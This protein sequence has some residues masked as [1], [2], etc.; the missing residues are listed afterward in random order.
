MVLRVLLILVAS[1]LSACT[2]NTKRVSEQKMRLNLY[3]EPPSLDPRKFTDSTSA[4]VLVMLFEGLTR[5][6][7]DHKP[8]PAAAEEILVSK[9][10]CVY[11]FKL[12]ETYWSNGERLT[13]ED[14]AY[15]WRKILDPK[16]PSLFAYKLYII[17]NAAEAKEGKLPIDDVGIRVV[18][19][20][21]LEVTLNHPASYFLELT[22]FPTFYPV[23]KKIA[24]SSAEWAAEAS[25]LFVS[26]GPFSLKKWEHESEIVVE[27]NPLYWDERSVYLQS[28]HLSMI[29]D[30]TTEFYMFEMGELD[31]AGSPISNL[32]PEFIPALKEEGKIKI[33]PA[34][35]VYYYKINTD[36]TALSNQK[37]RQALG[38]CINRKAIVEHITQ[39]GQQPAFGLVPALPGWKKS[40]CFKDGDIEYAQELFKEG[41]QELGMSKKHFPTITLSYNTSREHQ[42]IAQ[43]IQNQWKEGLGI[44]VE[45]ETS[46]WKVYLSKINKQDYQI[47]RMGWI[48]DFHDPLSFL[49][50]FKFKDNPN[51]GGNNET[52]WEHPAYIA[53]LNLAEQETNDKKRAEILRKAEELLISEMPLIPIFYIN[54]AYLKKPYVRGEYTSS[55]GIIDFKKA[56]LE[57]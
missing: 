51:L 55:L 6:G 49:E 5:I 35:A 40:T 54:Y 36:H 8:H 10:K 17:K 1:L 19:T 12:R 13:A 45:L 15:A 52:G 22:A 18:D 37:I 23:N 56:Y 26:N 27:K 53:Y 39:A 11:T 42:K 9:D 34:T 47:G 29:D 57:E 24:E 25:P 41:L 16:F 44:K 14:F 21:T 4:N 46:D 30:T 48:G 2:G 33:S 32:P 20:N 7:Y 28:I 3:C 38:Y 31:W 50:P 43:A